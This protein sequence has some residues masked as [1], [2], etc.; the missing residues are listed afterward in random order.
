M[1]RRSVV[2]LLVLAASLPLAAQPPHTATVARAVT[3]RAGPDPVFPPVT[4]LPQGEVVSVAGCIEGRRW[5]DVTAGRRRGWV[6]A[7]YLGRFDAR[8]APPL[9]FSVEEY[10]TAHYRQWAWYDDRARWAGFGTPAFNPPPA[11]D[12]WPRMPR[13]I[14]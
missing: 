8:R 4:W 10:W 7:S 5:C 2:A 12:R 3:V 6:N 9:T 13:G 14:P 1:L 11:P